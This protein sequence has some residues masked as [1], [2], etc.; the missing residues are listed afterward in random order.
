MHLNSLHGTLMQCLRHVF[1]VSKK[2][3]TYNIVALL[4]LYLLIRSA[5]RGLEFITVKSG[6][7]EPPRQSRL[8]P[9]YHPS[10]C[11]FANFVA[12]LVS[13]SL[14]CLANMV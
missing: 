6:H 13:V 12:R 11:P 2:K 8:I 7:D 9:N 4:N 14:A 10:G 1:L 5:K 3:L